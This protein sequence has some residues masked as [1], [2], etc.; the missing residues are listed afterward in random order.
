MIQFS[1][2]RNIK[3]IRLPVKNSKKKRFISYGLIG[4]WKIQHGNFSEKNDTELIG[5]T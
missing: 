2:S 5:K 1:M 4:Y 3:K